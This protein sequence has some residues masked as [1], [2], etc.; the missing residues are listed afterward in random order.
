LSCPF[1]KLPIKSDGQHWAPDVLSSV[2]PC[3]TNIEH[4]VVPE[5]L[6]IFLEK[7]KF[8]HRLVFKPRTVDPLVQSIPLLR[9]DVSIQHWLR[10]SWTVKLTIQQQ[11]QRTVASTCWLLELCKLEMLTIRKAVIFVLPLAGSRSAKSLGSWLITCRP[12]DEGQAFPCN[13]RHIAECRR[14]EI[15]GYINTFW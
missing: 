6:C 12:M 2:M 5:R 1:G 14:S 9:Y 11:I 7:I 10:A 3:P 8:W 15:A 4:W 13:S